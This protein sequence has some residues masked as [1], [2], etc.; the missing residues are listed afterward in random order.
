M[1]V[2]KIIYICIYIYIYKSKTVRFMLG[3]QILKG[4]SSYFSLK[5]V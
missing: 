3:F 1:G 5:I 4:I 2:I